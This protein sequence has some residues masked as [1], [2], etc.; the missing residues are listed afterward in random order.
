MRLRDLKDRTFR[1]YDVRPVSSVVFDRSYSSV[2]AS[3]AN[4]LS[5]ELWQ[6]VWQATKDL[7]GDQH[8]AAK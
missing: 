3:V 4:A 8:A 6:N 7:I 1:E 5:L 2:F